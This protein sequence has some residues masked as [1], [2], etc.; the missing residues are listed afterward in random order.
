MSRFRSAFD[1]GNIVIDKALFD[2]SLETGA[3]YD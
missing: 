3:C 1:A 2:P